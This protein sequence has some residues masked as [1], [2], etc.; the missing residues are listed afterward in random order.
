MLRILS[1]V[2]LIT[3]YSFSSMASTGDAENFINNLA[4]RVINI[5]KNQAISDKEKEST[6]NGIFVQTVDTKWIARFAMG[7]YWRSISTQDQQ[8]YLN[9]FKAYLTSI[10]VPNF[11]K[12]TSNKVTVLGSKATGDHEY[13]VQTSL[14]DA[15][16]TM[17]LKIDYRLMQ[18]PQNPKNFV[19]FDIVAEG[20]S[21]IT[22]QRADI[23]SI[24]SD[25]GFNSLV[26]LLK[27]KTI[28]E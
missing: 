16:K 12:Y 6:L 23:T 13:L 21:L 17:D 15:Q 27:Q 26:D 14:T 8:Q 28:K 3:T 24:M 2:L 20:V 18:D 22:T 5:V 10:Y 19:I 9:L 25:S 11:R 7:R 1:I 4:N